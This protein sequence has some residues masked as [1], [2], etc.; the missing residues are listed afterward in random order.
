MHHVDPMLFEPHCVGKGDGDDG[1]DRTDDRGESRASAPRRAG[2]RGL[3][4]P[5]T[6]ALVVNENGTASR[7]WYF[8]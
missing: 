2:G 8:R 4:A 3:V 6:C 5:A 1:A 7:P